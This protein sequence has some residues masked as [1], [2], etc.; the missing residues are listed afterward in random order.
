MW[1]KTLRTEGGGEGSH[2]SPARGL[3]QTTSP[4]PRLPR[5]SG[6]SDTAPGLADRAGTPQY[7]ST[8]LLATRPPGTPVPLTPRPPGILAPWALAP[9]PPAPSKVSSG[10]QVCGPNTGVHTT[11]TRCLWLMDC[12][13][14]CCPPTAP[15]NGR[16]SGRSHVRS[17]EPP[18]AT[19]AFP[20]PSTVLA[21]VLKMTGGQLAAAGLLLPLSVSLSQGSAPGTP[22]SG[23]PRGDLCLGPPGQGYQAGVSVPGTPSS[24]EWGHKLFFQAQPGIQGEVGVSTLLAAAGREGRSPCSHPAPHAAPALASGGSRDGHPGAL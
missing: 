5:C 8:Q 20:L 11:G 7:P 3:A 9:Q 21:S 19:Q 4:G 1:P 16:E 12:T 17:P 13:G 14:G 6:H 23:A 24:A 18:A 10:P 2:P 22:G 15:L